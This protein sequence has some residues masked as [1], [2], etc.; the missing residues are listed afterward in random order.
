[1]NRLCKSCIE[2]D[3]SAAFT[4][5]CVAEVS[6]SLAAALFGIVPVQ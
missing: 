1:M 6:L 4:V 3:V 2:G 5:L